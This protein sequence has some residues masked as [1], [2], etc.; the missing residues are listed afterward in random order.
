MQACVEVLRVVPERGVSRI[1]HQLQLRVRHR[2]HVLVNDTWLDDRV[3]STVRDQH[4]FA[5]LPQNFVVVERT[6]LP[7]RWNGWQGAGHRGARL[8]L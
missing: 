4:R 6:S 1:F 5:D 7:L 3:R 8:R 2:R